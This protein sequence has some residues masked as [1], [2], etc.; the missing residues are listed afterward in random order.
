MYPD[1]L[2]TASLVREKMTETLEGYGKSPM[3]DEYWYQPEE[4]KPKWSLWNFWRKP[5]V[6]TKEVFGGEVCNEC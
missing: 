5:K 4:Q 6:Q 1:P 2:I 3:P